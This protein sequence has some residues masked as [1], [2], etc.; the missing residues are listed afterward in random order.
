MNCEQMAEYQVQLAF[1]L[2]RITYIQ[3]KPGSHRVCTDHLQ[4]R[5]HQVYHQTKLHTEVKSEISI[6]ILASAVI[7]LSLEGNDDTQLRQTKGV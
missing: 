3:S 6:D 7:L 2:I 4:G 1:L 5:P